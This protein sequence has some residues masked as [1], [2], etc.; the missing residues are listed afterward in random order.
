MNDVVAVGFC[1]IDDHA[2]LNRHYPT[3][4]GVD[5]VVNMSMLG[6]DT[7][8]VSAVGRDIY[9]DEM[10]ELLKKNSIDSSHLHR[11]DGDTSF[12]MMELKN[13]DRIHLKNIKG[14][15]ENFKLSSDDVEFIKKYSYIH[16][17]FAGHIESYFPQF[18]E[19]GCKIFFD[20]SKFY[21]KHDNTEKIMKNVD[22]AFMSYT[23]KDDFII[24]YIK[25]MQKLGPKAVTATLGENGS[26]CF[27]GKKYYE[28]KAL[29][30]D[31]VNTV[32][33]GDSFIA[34]FMYGI[35]QSWDI[36]KCL[37]KGTEVS[38]KIIQQFEPY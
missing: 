2:N 17:D 14:V 38:S 33:A 4:N 24:K 16:S 26:I 29:K 21:L 18:K 30:V 28:Q 1:C 31:V 25:D 15:M 36:Q 11:I 34:G 19:A 8:L 9:G 13:N 20:F 23:E 22:Y 12:M 3:G 35:I 6:I 5:C 10:F 37:I 7:A 27:D 32:G